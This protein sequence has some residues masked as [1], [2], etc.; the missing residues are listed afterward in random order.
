MEE[1]FN[2]A[3]FGF[4]DRLFLVVSFGEAAG[5]GVEFVAEGL[6][7]KYASLAQAPRGSASMTVL[8]EAIAS[9][10]APVA[11]CTVPRRKRR[12]GSPGRRRQAAASSA[13]ASASRR[14]P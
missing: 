10:K 9:S 3:F 2:R 4:L 14:P 11:C 5:L 12:A 6:G 13:S 8:Y 1:R 7:R